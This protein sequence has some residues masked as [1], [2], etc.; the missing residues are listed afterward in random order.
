VQRETNK[1]SYKEKLNN[2]RRSDL[3]KRWTTEDQAFDEMDLT[4]RAE[5]LV[6]GDMQ[7]VQKSLMDAVMDKIAMSGVYLVVEISH[8]GKR[9]KV[10]GTVRGVADFIARSKPPVEDAKIVEISTDRNWTRSKAEEV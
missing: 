3:I 7:A 1:S 5:I 8:D 4:E 6:K 2:R 10:S 9:F